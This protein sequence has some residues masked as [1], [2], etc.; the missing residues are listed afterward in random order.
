MNFSEQKNIGLYA[1][2]LSHQDSHTQIYKLHNCTIITTP[3]RSYA[4]NCEFLTES[5]QQYLMGYGNTSRRDAGSTWRAILRCYTGCGETGYS[6]SGAPLIKDSSL[7]ISVSHTANMVAIGISDSTCGIDI[8]MC[9]RN[10]SRVSG[11]YMTRN[12][13]LLHNPYGELWEGVVWCAKEA[14]YKMSNHSGLDFK[15]N[16]EVVSATENSLICNVTI[17]P[18]DT[19]QLILNVMKV[20]EHICVWGTV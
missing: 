5:E 9:G 19:K 14:L 20:E 12:E 4:E 18:E 10:F 11:R 13:T 15:R 3:I 6:D 1:N 8:E 7:H 17:P 16:M 2:L